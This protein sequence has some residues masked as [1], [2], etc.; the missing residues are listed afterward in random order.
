M[1]ADAA[2]DSGEQTGARRAAPG[3][4]ALVQAFVNTNDREGRED[5]FDTLHGLWMWLEGASLPFDDSE[6]GESERAQAIELREGIRGLARLHSG[7]DREAPHPGELEGAIGR[8]DLTA[9]YVGGQIALT[10]RTPVGIVLAP[11]V[12]AMRSAMDNLTW[13]RLKVCERDKCQWLF[14]DHS[15]NRTAHWC[16]TDLCG[17]REKARRAYARRTAA[18]DSEHNSIG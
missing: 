6:I 15:R 4:L 9:S 12:D 1:K 7:Q 16:T 14:Y 18:H 10:G 11:I 8:L 13:S 17:S 2:S 5:R 3:R